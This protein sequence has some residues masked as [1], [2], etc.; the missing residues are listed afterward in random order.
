MFKLIAK[1]TSNLDYPLPKIGLEFIEQPRIVP[2][3][4]KSVLSYGLQRIFVTQQ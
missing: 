3:D 4:D 2:V 1:T